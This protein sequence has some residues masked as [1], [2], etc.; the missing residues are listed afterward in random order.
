MKLE[1]HE[2]TV[3]SIAITPNGNSIVSGGQDATVR[4]WDL[5]DGKEVHMLSDHQ[6]PVYTLGITSDGHRIVS[7]A[8]NDLGVRIWDLETGSLLST[9]APNSEDISALTIT[10]DDREVITVAND[11]IARI[12]DLDLGVLKGTLAHSSAIYSCRI[13]PDGRYLITGSKKKPG[14]D[15]IG[16]VWIWDYQNKKL[17]RTLEGH[18]GSVTALTITADSRYALSGGQG[19][20]VNLWDLET[21]FL[22]KSMLGHK[23]PVVSITIAPDGNHVIT[24]SKDGTVRV[25][26]L[27]GG[28]LLKA[29][30]TTENVQSIAITPDGRQVVA[31]TLE[32]V[33]RVLDFEVGSPWIATDFT[34]TEQDLAELEAFRMMQLR[35]VIARYEK[36]PLERLATLLRFGSIEELEDWLLEIPI[37]IPVRIAGTNIVIRK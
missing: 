20:L 3:W 6:G 31:G 28:V 19:G 8:G 14:T 15:E 16:L 30:E 1:G 36:L 13:S 10:P 22:L 18:Q 29:L 26:L 5:I 35:K 24:G 9:L 17:L 37:E 21:G 2:F 32:G 4:V 34:T 25:W 7:A 23:S 27:R 11:K 33:I 12:W